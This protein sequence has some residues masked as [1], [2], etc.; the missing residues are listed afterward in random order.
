MTKLGIDPKDIPL[1]RAE[2]LRPLWWAQDL[3]R[4][5][6]AG[7]HLAECPC[8]AGRVK[9]YSRALGKSIRG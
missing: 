2:L 6:L 4:E 3:L 8:C 1:P 9:V 5:A 7:G